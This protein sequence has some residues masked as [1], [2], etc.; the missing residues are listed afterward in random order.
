MGTSSHE[1]SPAQF[2]LDE[3]YAILNGRTPLADFTAQYGSLWPYL[4]AA[5][6][7]RP[8]RRSSPSR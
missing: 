6:L 3:T 7:A 4:P 8:A 1:W 2:T 5:V